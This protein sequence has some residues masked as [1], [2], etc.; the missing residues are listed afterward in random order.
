MEEMTEYR[1][2][3]LAAIGAVLSL[4]SFIVMCGVAVMKWAGVF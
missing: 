1:I 4:A 2:E 3:W